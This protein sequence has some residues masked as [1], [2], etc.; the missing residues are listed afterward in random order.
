MTGERLGKLVVELVP[1][2]IACSEGKGNAALAIGGQAWP[3]LALRPPSPELKRFSAAIE[4]ESSRW[5]RWLNEDVLPSVPSAIQEALAIQWLNVLA[6][7]VNWPKV[8]AHATALS[9]RTFENSTIVTNLVISPG[10]GSVDITDPSLSKLTPTLGSSMQSF[11]R[12]DS[13]L[14]VIAYEGIPWGDI[15][16]AGDYKLYPEFLHPV[17]S[18][19]ELDDVSVHHTGRGDLLVM[20]REGIRAARRKGQ[21]RIYEPST[22]RDVVADMLGSYQVATNVFEFLLDLSFRRRGALL[23]YDPSRSTLGHV[24][25][26]KSMVSPKAG[27]IDPFRALL[28]DAI[29]NVSMGTANGLT[30]GKRLMMELASLDGAVIFDESQ[31]LAVGAMIGTH[32]QAGN[33]AGARTTAALSALAY[34]A[35]PIKVSADGDIELYFAQENPWGIEAGRPL[36]FL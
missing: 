30:G 17:N 23:I 11:L 29:A 9:T 12:V 8:L 2:W 6:P 13:E 14:R 20:K 7:S 36:S 19:L 15:R 24:V 33:H 18:I 3:F 31:I 5:D 10:Q 1:H 25:N 21:W 32:S 4:E 26:G 27:S 34:G 22:L 28:R 35:Y 16:D